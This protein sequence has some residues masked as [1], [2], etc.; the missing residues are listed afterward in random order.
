MFK[1]RFK[2]NSKKQQILTN[3]AQ[4]SNTKPQL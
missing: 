3:V 4:D 1:N 2:T